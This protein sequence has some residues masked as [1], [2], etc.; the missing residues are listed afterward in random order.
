LQHRLGTAIFGHRVFYYPEIGSTNDRALE[1]AAAGEPEG[2]LVLS[3]RQTQGRGR[4]DR[5]WTSPAWLGIYTSVLLRPRIP[6]NRAPLFTVMAAVATA[7]GLRKA[8]GLNTGIKWPND[9]V[10]GHR[11]IAGILGEVRGSDPRIHEMV[12]GIGVNVNHEAHDFPPE[13]S[14]L[15]TSVR[16]EVGS[17]R[18]RLGI[19]AEILEQ[20]ER[21]YSALL[22]QGS[23]ELLAEWRTLSTMPAGARLAIETSGGAVEGS[24]QGIDDEGALML[25]D[26]AGRTM[27]VPFGE[28]ESSLRP[29]E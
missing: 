21:R 14:R 11:K 28:I 29:L 15:A 1:L 2:A 22:R 26:S 17:P 23:D 10:V 13:L 4:R 20:F 6:A 19:L 24:L 16:M 3:E 8:C 18:D 12:V 27:R 7:L 5:A 9:V 25:A